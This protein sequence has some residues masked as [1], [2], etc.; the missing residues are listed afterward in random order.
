MS[1]K[2]EQRKAALRE[3]LVH[4]AKVRIESDGMAALRARDLAKDAGCAVGAIYNAFEDLND[5]VMAVNGLTF[6]ALGETVRS[7]FDGIEP[8][9]DRLILMSHAYLGFAVDHTNLW[10]A[11]FDL[12]MSE[13][14]PVPAWYRAALADL[15]SNISRPLS[16]LFPEMTEQ[17]L[18]LMTRAMFSSVHGI[19]LLGLQNRISGVPPEQIE[20]MI[21]AVLRRIGNE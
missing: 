21:A 11:L 2:S 19:V 10:R 3:K 9:V 13:D 8:P 17:E 14:G 12:D 7:S 5:I 18:S 15:F 4:S 16:E 1:T 20:Q 6:Q